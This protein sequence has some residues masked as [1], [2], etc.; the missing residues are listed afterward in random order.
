MQDNEILSG[1]DGARPSPGSAGPDAVMVFDACHVGVVLRAVLFVEIVAGVAAM[2]AADAL[3]DWWL[4]WALLSAAALPAT[5]V[6]LI[7]ACRSKTWLAR[8]AEPGQYAAGMLLGALSGVYGC[9]ML[10]WSGLVGRPAWTTSAVA[11]AALAL[12]LVGGLVLRSRGRA[13]AAAT[14]RLAALQARI[15]P[16]FLFNTLNTAIALVRAEPARAEALLEDL[17]ELFR[18]ALAEHG[19]SVAL[20]DEIALARTYLAIEQLRFGQRLRIEWTLDPQAGQA[21]LPPLMLQPLVENAVRHGVQPSESGATLRISTLLRG[22]RVLIK[23]ANT[24]P[25]GAGDAGHGLGLRN[26]GERLRLLHDLQG[27]FRAGRV[28]PWYQV[29]IEI[30]A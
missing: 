12:G 17:S 19:A 18:H 11:G 8:L 13:P 3:L 24:V 15:E 1:F 20:S 28:G 6:W 23:V 29:R 5:L 30:P 2:F 27:R 26:V 16:H 22:G 14:A 9:A 4:Q 25:A 7:V 10:A 21:R